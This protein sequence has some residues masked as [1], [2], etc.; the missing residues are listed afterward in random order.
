MDKSEYNYT[1]CLLVS[2]AP[3]QPVGLWGLLLH[4][5]FCQMSSLLLEKHAEPSLG[6]RPGSN[7]LTA[8]V[9]GNTDSGTVPWE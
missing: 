8:S 9:S 6:S 3:S 4:S 2:Q 5:R 1:A 7:S